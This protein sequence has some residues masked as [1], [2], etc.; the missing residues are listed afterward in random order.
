MERRSGARGTM[1]TKLTREA[2]DTAV[3]RR[4]VAQAQDFVVLRSSDLGTDP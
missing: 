3:C 4:F 1:R 2:I